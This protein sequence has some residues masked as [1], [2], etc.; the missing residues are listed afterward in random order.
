MRGSEGQAR[1][2]AFYLPAHPPLDPTAP[3]TRA[4]P[5]HRAGYL[6]RAMRLPEASMGGIHR[7]FRPHSTPRKCPP[8]EAAGR[9]AVRSHP[10]VASSSFAS[11]AY[12]A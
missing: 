9:R 5:L 2:E 8:P 1:D 4:P 6:P 10:A 7:V 12:P 11:G 3:S